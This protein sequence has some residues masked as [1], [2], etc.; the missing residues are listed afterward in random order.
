MKAAEYRDVLQVSL[1]KIENVALDC[2]LGGSAVADARIGIQE[3][4]SYNQLR[5][6]HKHMEG[7]EY[8]AYEVIRIKRCVPEHIWA[9]Y[10]TLGITGLAEQELL[11]KAQRTFRKLWRAAF[12]KA[13][14]DEPKKK[15]RK[16]DKSADCE[17][18]V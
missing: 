5:A 9:Q 14:T 6:L 3:G 17:V 12:V 16:A 4:F 2:G 18:A 11:S 7:L 15:R 1:D 13:D 10:K 8:A